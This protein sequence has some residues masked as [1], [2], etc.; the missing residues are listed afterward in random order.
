MAILILKA[1]GKESDVCSSKRVEEV[2]SNLK[3]TCSVCTVDAFA[4]LTVNLHH[5]PKEAD[6]LSVVLK[7]RLG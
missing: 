1:S 5:F 2:A 4:A 7:Q 3:E 6:A